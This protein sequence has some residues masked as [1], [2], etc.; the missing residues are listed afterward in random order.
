MAGL[1]IKHIVLE[2][3]N[4]VRHWKHPPASLL[5]VKALRNIAVVYRM[6]TKVIAQNGNIN[7]GSTVQNSHTAN[8]KVAGACFA[9]GDGSKV[10]EYQN[11]VNVVD[12]NKSEQSESSG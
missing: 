1:E 11:E 3:M 12:V 5:G 8:V 4:I 10:V 9:F 2:G 7:V 6:N